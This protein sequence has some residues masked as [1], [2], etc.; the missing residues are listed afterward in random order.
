MVE[1]K[2]DKISNF[3]DNEYFL[4]LKEYFSSHDIL[5]I[6]EYNFYGSKRIDSYADKV[7]KEVLDKCLPVA[8]NWFGSNTMVPTYGIFSEY[9]GKQAYLDKHKDA[10][11]CTYT[12]DICL[13]QNNEWPLFIEDKEYVFGEN[14]AVMFF[15]NDQYHWRPDF[16][17]PDKNKVGIL[18]LHYV[19]PEHSW[20]NLPEQVR[21]LLRNRTKPA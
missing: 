3:F 2:S 19:E 11:P 5:S 16:P 17:N 12:I 7:L 4:Y 10:G 8:K 14:E 9:S 13:Y 6:P 1:I 20:F 21:I 15:A 18:L